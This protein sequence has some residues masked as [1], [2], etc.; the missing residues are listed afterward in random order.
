MRDDDLGGGGS[1]PSTTAPLGVI[2]VGGESRRYGRPKALEPV[3][4][5]PMAEH[6]RLALA[7]HVS[8][9]VAVG[10]ALV[11][12]DALGIP[13][14]P[15]DRVDLGPM[16]G[17][18][19]GLRWAGEL[20]MHGVFLLAC[21]LPLVPPE[22]VAMILGRREG[23]D[24]AIPESRGPRGCEP[25]CAWYG[26]GCQILI[27]ETLSADRR[28][29]DD[30]LRAARVHRLSLEDVEEV[31]DPEVAFLNVNTPEDRVAAEELLRK[32][33]REAPDEMRNNA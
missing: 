23:V 26:P 13:V 8:Q 31:V 5:L 29:M 21:D 3:A 25:L 32:T 10:N 20:G 11:L 9:V 19:T 15:D 27:E 16:G 30:L 2:L 6:S 4:G 14:R 18:L 28:A 24:V 7:P 33:P 12:S 1:P 17:L 22:L